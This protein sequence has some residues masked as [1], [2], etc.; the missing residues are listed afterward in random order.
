MDVGREIIYLQ[1]VS[2]ILYSVHSHA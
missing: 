1:E 2:I